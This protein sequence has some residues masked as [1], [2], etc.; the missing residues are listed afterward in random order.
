M[1]IVLERMMPA[2]LELTPEQY[3]ILVAALVQYW[4]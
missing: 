4:Y 2:I 1:S 3:L